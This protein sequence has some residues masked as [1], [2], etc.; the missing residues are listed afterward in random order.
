MN[1][2]EKGEREKG[3]K[4]ERNE[5]D[6]AINNNSLEESDS[7]SPFD[8]LPSSPF[9]PSSFPPASKVALLGF[10]NVGRAFARYVGKERID[11]HISAVADSSGG[12][13]I[14]APGEVEQ[15]VARKES[16]QSIR[17]FRP[18]SVIASA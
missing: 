10:G 16:G 9:S 3:E 11:I 18:D 15:L 6:F 12:L 7:S 17:D 13:I 14:G 1:K 5:C 8:L 4:E 2:G